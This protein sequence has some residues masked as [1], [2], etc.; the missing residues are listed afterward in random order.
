MARKNIRTKKNAAEPLEKYTKAE[1]ID[2]LHRLEFYADPF[3]RLGYLEM[4]VRDTNIVIR[5][6]L[7]NLAND[8]SDKIIE[9]HTEAIELIRPYEGKGF[10]S[11]PA[12]VMK[13]IKDCNERARKYG[14]ERDRIMRR[15]MHE[16]D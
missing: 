5:T 11:V 7:N 3:R 15:I 8:L 16:F 6:R 13:K 2:I 10:S 1:L 14:A 9:A 12:S 4:A